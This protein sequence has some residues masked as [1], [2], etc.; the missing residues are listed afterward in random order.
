MEYSDE[1]MEPIPAEEPEL[2]QVEITAVNVPGS[3][4]IMTGGSVSRSLL[5]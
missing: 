1:R 2:P 5:L 3:Y 4:L